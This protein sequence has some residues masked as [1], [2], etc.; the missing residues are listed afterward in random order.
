MKKLK[1]DEYFFSFSASNEPVLTVNSGSVV[2]IE[3]MDCFSNQI[4]D[5]SNAFEKFDWSKV[6][7]ATGPIYVEEAEPLDTLKVEILDISVSKMGIMVSGED[8]GV[9][10]HLLKGLKVKMI[11]IKDDL[12]VF[13]EKLSIPLNKMIGVIGVAPSLEKGDVMCGSPGSHGG[14]M[15]N[16]MITS[17]ATL[18]LPIFVK[19]ALFGLGDL[20]AAM[21][22]GEIGVTGVEVSG[23]VKVR[24]E[25]VKKI[26]IDDPLLLNDRNFTTIASSETIDAAISKATENMAAMLKDKLPL[27]MHEIAMLLSAVGHAQVCQVVDPLKTARFVMPMDVLKAY[28]FELID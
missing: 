4:K 1:S 15:D 28:D 9:L 25:V 18:F 26:K 20:H 17:G 16:L 22:D 13:D 7:P 19:G 12:A 21:G 14:N 2:E 23:S 10:G 27:S 24:L 5:I 11:P 3:T 8:E 6:N